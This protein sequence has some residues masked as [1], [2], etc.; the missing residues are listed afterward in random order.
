MHAENNTK[1]L[2]NNVSSL[3]QLK[4]AIH[5]F[6]KRLNIASNES[7]F[8]TNCKY[9]LTTIQ[10]FEYFRFDDRWPLINYLFEYMLINLHYTK[11]KK[12]QKTNKIMCNKLRG[13]IF[14][15]HDISIREK[16]SFYLIKMST[17]PIL[18]E[19]ILYLNNLYNNIIPMEVD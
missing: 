13:L 19:E 1:D 3:L 2:I 9:M 7:I 6:E 14:S 11:Q 12:F 8:L 5:Y 15:K 16:A 17:T 4:F 10:N 18:D